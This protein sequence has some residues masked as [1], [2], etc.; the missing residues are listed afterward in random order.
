[1]TPHGSEFHGPTPDGRAS[2]SQNGSSAI[3]CPCCGATPVAAGVPDSRD[4][5]LWCAACG[6]LLLREIVSNG[7]RASDWPVECPAHG[8]LRKVAQSLTESG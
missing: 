6:W 8:P 5:D 4:G 3:R 1:M 7:S 2:I